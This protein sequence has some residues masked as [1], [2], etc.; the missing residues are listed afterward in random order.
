[1]NFLIAAVLG[2]VSLF[3]S[4]VLAAGARGGG[5]LKTTLSHSKSPC[6]G[7]RGGAMPPTKAGTKVVVRGVDGGTD[8]V[9]LSPIPA[10]LL[11][12]HQAISPD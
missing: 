5:E 9:S 1:M 11:H 3:S 2:T 10:T 6:Q 8:S 12:L 4:R 7:L